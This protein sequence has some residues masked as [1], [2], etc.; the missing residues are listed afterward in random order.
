MIKSRGHKCDY[1]PTDEEEIRKA[2]GTLLKQ[3]P[4]VGAYLVD[5]DRDEVVAGNATMAVV[6]SGE[7]YLGHEYNETLEYVILKEK[8]NVWLDSWAVTKKL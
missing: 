5:E 8:S 4:D 2:Y 6:Y 3:K 7:A 1:R